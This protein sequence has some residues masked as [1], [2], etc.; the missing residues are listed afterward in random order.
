MEGKR[1]KLKECDK[2][3]RKKESQSGVNANRRK[4]GE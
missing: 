4:D 2:E 1:K 3:L